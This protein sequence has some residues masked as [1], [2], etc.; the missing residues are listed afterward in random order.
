MSSMYLDLQPFFSFLHNCLPSSRQSYPSLASLLVSSLS[1]FPLSSALTNCSL[2]Q[3]VL[4]SSFSASL[5]F[6]PNISLPR[7]RP[8]LLHS[9]SYPANSPSLFFFIILLLFLSPFPHRSRVFTTSGGVV[10]GSGAVEEPPKGR[11][12][13]PHRGEPGV[14]PIL[15]CVYVCVR[16][17]SVLSKGVM[18]TIFLHYS[19]RVLKFAVRRFYAQTDFV[20]GVLGSV[21]CVCAAVCLSHCVVL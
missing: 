20:A 12:W 7:P 11:H 16:S 19:C 4:S 5:L 6:A 8:A 13:C 2:V 9:S 21:I 3:H 1:F 18:G 10:L 15:I 14:N 17:R